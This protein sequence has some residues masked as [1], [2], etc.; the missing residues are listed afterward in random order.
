MSGP[1]F[2][3]SDQGVGKVRSPINRLIP[4]AR[5]VEMPVGKTFIAIEGSERSTLS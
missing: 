4:D 1:I 5:T 3:G 2:F